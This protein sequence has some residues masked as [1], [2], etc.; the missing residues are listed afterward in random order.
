MHNSATLAAPAAR[1]HSARLSKLAGRGL[2]YLVLSLIAVITVYPFWW[3]LVTALST[4]GDVFA[5][6]PPL[7]PSAPSL[8]NFKEAVSSIDLLAFYKNSVIIA[9]ATVAGTLLVSAL[10]AYRWR[11]C[12]FPAASWC[13]APSSPP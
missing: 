12:A 3:T 4:E 6:P 8:N 2:H 11:G 5:F 10:A 9:L 1:R 7:L 13:S